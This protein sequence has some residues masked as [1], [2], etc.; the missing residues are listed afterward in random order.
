MSEPLPSNR[1]LGPEHMLTLRCAIWQQEQRR[2]ERQQ[3]ATVAAW[4]TG[5]RI[6]G[7]GKAAMPPSAMTP[8][9]LL[10]YAAATAGVLQQMGG[11]VFSRGSTRF[12]AITRP[13][14]ARAARRSYAT[15]GELRGSHMQPGEGGRMQAA[16]AAQ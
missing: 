12:G 4:S 1:H 14:V 11:G 2:Q 15:R 16:R 3:A 13:V 7:A 9:R 8:T 5:R 6:G 10:H